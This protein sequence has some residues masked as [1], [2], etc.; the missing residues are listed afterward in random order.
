MQQLKFHAVQT[1][2]KKKGINVERMQPQTHD[3][4]VYRYEVW[5]TGASV[6]LCPTLWDVMV[7]VDS[8]QE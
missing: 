7:C 4:I 1:W 5:K 6:E 2:A 8:W 3:K